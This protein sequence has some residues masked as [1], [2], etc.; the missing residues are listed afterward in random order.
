MDFTLQQVRFLDKIFNDIGHGKGFNSIKDLVLSKNEY[1][2][3]VKTEL[4]ELISKSKIED[5]LR[6]K[7]YNYYIKP[8]YQYKDNLRQNAG[9]VLSKY[10]EF[11]RHNLILENFDGAFYMYRRYGYDKPIDRVINSV[12]FYDLLDE[13]KVYKIQ[14]DSIKEFENQYYMVLSLEI[15]CQTSECPI[16]K[17]RDY[18]GEFLDDVYLISDIKQFTRIYK[19]K[20]YKLSGF[21]NQGYVREYLVV[22]PL[23]LI[24]EKNNEKGY[25]KIDNF[26]IDIFLPYTNKFSRI[27]C[28]IL[29]NNIDFSKQSLKTFSAFDRRFAFS[30]T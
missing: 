30:N 12:Y 21:D 27:K 23:K 20:K 29:R 6:V 16:S 22:Y 13:S 26:S 14:G 5:A 2:D 24:F 19:G 28:S 4:S 10:F 1:K 7:I 9:F 3:E 8:V 15:G 17:M 18:Q 25:F 11:G